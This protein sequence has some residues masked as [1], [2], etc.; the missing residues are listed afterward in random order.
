[1]A[2]IRVLSV[3]LGLVAAQAWAGEGAGVYEL[4]VDGIACPF[5]AYGI[6][7]ELAAIPSVEKID[8]D[9][10]RGVI[11]VRLKDGATLDEA[12]AR[13]AAKNAGF[14]L[15]SFSESAAD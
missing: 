9:L 10:G 14:S 2:P 4:G 8:I 7:K 12:A 1:M 15:R 6:E 11:T 5:C 3:L 13:K